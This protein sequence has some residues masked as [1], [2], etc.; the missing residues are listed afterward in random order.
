MFWKK[1]RP[2]EPMPDELLPYERFF[3]HLAFQE[4]YEVK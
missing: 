3:K 4:V 2:N 1:Y